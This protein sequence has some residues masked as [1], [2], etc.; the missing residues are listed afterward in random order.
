MG[1]ARKPRQPR[2]VKLVRPSGK[3]FK[4]PAGFKQMEISGNFAPTHDFQVEANIQ[5]RVVE[6]KTVPK[7]GLIKKDTRIMVVRTDKGDRSV[8]ES[9]ALIGLFDTVKKG[10]TVLIHYTGEIKVKGRRQTMHGFEVFIK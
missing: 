3:G 8:W 5:G 4:P 6:I 7:G 10:K 2:E 1:H 9:T